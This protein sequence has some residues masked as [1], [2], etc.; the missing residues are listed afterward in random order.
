[1]A[2]SLFP[3]DMMSSGV[4][5][6]ETIAG[7]LAHFHEHL[8]L[9]HWQTKSYAEHKALGKIYE[10]V[11]EFKDD[12]IEKLMGYTGKRVGVYKIEPL[13]E[14]SSTIVVTSLMDFATNLKKY[15]EVNG[16]HDVANMADALSGEASKTRYLLTLS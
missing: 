11:Q 12:V 9:L 8:H 1:M 6:L 5:N 10:Y 13:S 7:K 3:D 2:K 4:L 15:A 16:Y 14:I